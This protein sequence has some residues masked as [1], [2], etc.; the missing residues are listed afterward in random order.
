MK[1]LTAPPSGLASHTIAGLHVPDPQSPTHVTHLE[2]KEEN[3]LR[4][5]VS[6][7]V[8]RLRPP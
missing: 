1:D 5:P 7:P 3:K 8:A 6:G 2:T 4:R